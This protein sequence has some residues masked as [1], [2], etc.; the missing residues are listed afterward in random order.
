[1][2]VTIYDIAEKAQVS[3]ATVS[4]VFNNHPRV[5]DDTRERV[6][7]VAERLGY[8]PHVSAQNLARRQ[9]HL[10]S[11]VIPVMTNYFF[12]EVL[13]GL[14]D[15]L[16]ESEY[17]LLAYTSNELEEVDVQI[18]R[19]IQRGRAEGLLL[20]STPITEDRVKRLKR[21]RQ[22]VVLVD[23]F[24]PE[25]DSVSIKNE[26][27]GYLA[28]TH[29]I[30]KGCQKIGLITGHPES[31]PSAE[32][33]KGYERA[34]QEAGRAMDASLMIS[35]GNTEEHGYTE[36]AGYTAMQSLLRRA[37]QPDAVFVASDIQA[38]GAMQAIKEARLSIPDDIAIIGFDDI[39]ISKYVGLTTLQQ[40]MYQMGK[41]AV[42]KFLM[43][44]QHPDLPVSHTVFS[45][46]L[47]CRTTCP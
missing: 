23:C 2:G 42:E 33:R 18:E 32:R 39:I 31:V 34:L 28:T 9:T 20:F 44:L 1:M 3:I 10:I 5:S 37:Q 16:S 36:Q 14:Q 15:R 27:G 6:L 11:A 29:F 24:H 22:P 8:Q 7:T 19:A 13:R 46:R 40:P 25:F 47:I 38:L 41:L 4:R 35:C 30:E 17:D 21:S 26:Q 45:P 43:R 12:V